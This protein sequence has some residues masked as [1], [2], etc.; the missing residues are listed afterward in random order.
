[1]PI[2][3]AMQCGCPVICSDSSSMPEVGGSAAI[4]FS[5]KNHID[6]KNKINHLLKNNKLREKMINNGYKQA[7]KFSWKK[8]ANETIALYTKV[9]NNKNP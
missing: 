4:Y 6:F 1:M 8:C 5:P 3:E 7:K 9:I 2:L